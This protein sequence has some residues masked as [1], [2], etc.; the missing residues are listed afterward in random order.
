MR[1]AK[2]IH[3]DFEAAPAEKQW[4]GGELE[5]LWV[6]LEREVPRHSPS[7]VG[8]VLPHGAHVG[9]RQLDAPD[10]PRELVIYRSTPF[11]SAAGETLWAAEILTF[12][13]CFKITSWE[14][15]NDFTATGGPRVWIRER[16]RTQDLF[17]EAF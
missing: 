17:S 9:M 2:K 15:A 5:A 4:R 10:G 12:L 1:T 6:F 3:P 8:V 14:K 7:W 16:V 11:R 13:R